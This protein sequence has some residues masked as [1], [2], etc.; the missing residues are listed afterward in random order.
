MCGIFGIHASVAGSI[1]PSA[2]RAAHQI[3]SHRGPDGRGTAE[4]R[5]GEGQLILA[6]Q[7]LAIIDLTAAGHQPMAYRNGAG[8][9]V[10]NGELYNYLELRSELKGQGEAFTSQSDTEV[11]LSA[12]HRWGVPTALSRFNWMGA[13][14]WFDAT[15]NRLVLARD[16]GS[17]KPLYYFTDR[18]RFVFA[19]EIKTLLTLVARRFAL[20]RDV[21]GRFLH[22]GLLDATPQTMF[23]GIQQLAAAHYLEIEFADPERAIRSMAYAPP[24]YDGEPARLALGDAVDE[25]RRL[26][27]DSVR[28]RLRSDVPV[29]VLLSG[30]VDSSAIA[31]VA[32]RQPGAAADPVLLSAVSGDPRFDESEFIGAVEAHLGRTARKVVLRVAAE[33]FVEDLTRLNWINDEPVTGLS[34]LAH[35]RLMECARESGITVVLSGQGADELFLGYRKY[36]GFYLQGLVRRRDYFKAAAVF[37]QFALN[38]SILTQFDLAEAKRYLPGRRAFG[39]SAAA[40]R[41]VDGEW[42][43]GWR[44][45]LIGLGARTLAE[46]QFAD[47][48]E[49]S[50]PALCHYEDRMSM[51]VGR[52]IRLPFLDSR[53]VD[54][55]LRVPIEY[56]LNRGWTKY[57]L[58]LAI[59]PWLPARITWRKD[60]R[61]FSNPQ[62]EWLKRELR[63]PVRDAFSA[64]SA[65]SRRGICNSAALLA[66]YERYCAQPPGRGAIWYREIFAPLSL[67][68]WLR[69]Y[70]DWIA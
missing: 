65:L 1:D 58:R 42:L 47:L 61:G 24:P 21:V 15:R 31:A 46:R 63:D 32:A 38:R 43:R 18:E 22:Q 8:S 4:F 55:M 16:P 36:L 25:V 44:P 19:S 33:T 29:G 60:K 66:K 6:H 45:A 34:A 48:R 40:E 30:G 53:L 54:L 67:E 28:L 62:G 11:L 41:G 9:L 49:F 69:T 7:R 56:K 14:A 17:E 3:Q 12:L 10:F 50:V 57:C 27:C 2:I 37:T 5:I 59:E 64:D 51:A 13:F 70:G 52:E 68:I 26:L 20:D 35:L 39:R 23:R